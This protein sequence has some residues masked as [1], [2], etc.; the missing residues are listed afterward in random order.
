VFGLAPCK[1]PNKDARKE[2]SDKLIFL[3]V[4]LIQLEETKAEVESIECS[5][6]ISNPFDSYNPPF[7]DF[8]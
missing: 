8:H 2:F 1:E 6:K 3:L 4:L 7:L 5:R